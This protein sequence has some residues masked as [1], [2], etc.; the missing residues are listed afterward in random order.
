[1][2]RFGSPDY[3]LLM[4][5][6]RN[7]LEK[8]NIRA[9]A[10]FDEPLAAHTTF[11]LGGPA[12]ALVAPRTRDDLLVLLREAGAEGIPCF[13]LGGGANVVVADRGIRGIVVETRHLDGVAAEGGRVDEG[14]VLV[15]EAGLSVDRLCEA[16]LERRL[17]GLETFYGM[18]GS[19]GGAVFMNARCYEVEMADRLAWVESVLRDGSGLG[20]QSTEAGEWAYKSSPYQVGKRFAGRIVLA[21]GFA[22]AAGEPLAIRRVMGEKR[23]DREA[24]G[25]YR[26]PSAGSV[27]KN[28]RA[29]GKPTGRILDELG[30]RGRRIGG[31][32]VSEWHANIFV[33]AGGA[34]ASDLRKLVELAKGEARDRL[35]IELEPEILFV[36]DFGAD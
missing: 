4:P 2:R 30:F 26:L 11:R 5:T 33:N 32:M 13:I 18:P 9:D 22:L 6:L 35:G 21:A 14:G 15:A 28:N 36:G 29:F 8:I 20:R 1:M 23:A 3:Y 31:A 7:F 24:K 10:R 17:G 12:D 25:H 27:F 16:A 34:T 19:V